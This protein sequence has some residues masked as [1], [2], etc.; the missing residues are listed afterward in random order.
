MNHQ[1]RPEKLLCGGLSGKATLLRVIVAIAFIASS[2]TASFSQSPEVKKALRYIDIEQPSK[3]ISAMEQLVSAN[4][5]NSSYLYYLGLAQIRTGNKDKAL[6][7]FEKGIALNEKDGLNHAGKGHIKLLDKNAAEAKLSLDKAVSVSKSKDANVLRA[8]GEAFLSDSKYLIDAFNYLNK[9]KG[10]NAI[11][12]ETHIL[13]GD[14]YLLQN[15]GGES[16]SSYERAAKADPKLAKPHHKV[17]LV[18]M[19]SRNVD[20]ALESLNK[21]ITI[22]PEYAPAFKELGEIYYLRKEAEKAVK[23]YESY[24]AITE[25]PGDA[26]FQLAFFYFMAKN[27]E[28]ANAIFKEVLNKPDASTTALRYYAYSLVEQS[29]NDPTKVEEARNIFE[30]YFKKAK[31]EDIKASDY[32]YYAKLLVKIPNQDSL[33][34]EAIAKSLALDSLQP[35][36]LQIHGDTYMKRKKYAEAV[37]AYKQLI[38]QRKQPLSQDLFA[39]GRAYYQN[40]QFPEADTAFTKL[41]EKQPNMTVGYLWA[42]RSRQHIDSTGVQ[43]LAKPMYEQVVEKG[44]QNPEKYKKD[45]IEAYDYLGTYHLQITKDVTLAKG[46]FEKVLALDPANARAKEFMQT[47]KQPGTKGGR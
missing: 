35:E 21:A 16:V 36:M 18:Y 19:R 5:T 34:N 39:I 12:P 1:V 17:A 7:N 33:V 38:A 15:N 4:P 43:G 46:F 31:T 22:D 30:Q 9:A 23:A 24:L 10:I 27:Y 42:G 13:L 47:L 37:G 29:K 3:G 32:E 44:S 14:A 28:K 6:A 41:A 11:D 8:V 40:E 2:S 25:K 20:I 26:R 45:L